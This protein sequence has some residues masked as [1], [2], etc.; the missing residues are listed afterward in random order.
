MTTAQ[1]ETSVYTV[2]QAAGKLAISDE[3][4][5]S[6]FKHHPFF[7]R[8]ALRPGPGTTRVSKE[9]FDQYLAGTLVMTE[10]EAAWR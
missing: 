2:P 8:M 3:L 10:E 1:T 9:M 4:A 7:K 5:Y 6:R